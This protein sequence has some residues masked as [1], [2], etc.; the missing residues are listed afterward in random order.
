MKVVVFGQALIHEPV[1][2]SDDL[3]A[4]TQGA[5]AVICNFEGCLPPPEVWPMKSKTVHAAHPASL[6][7]L[8]DL[9]VTHLSVANNH[10]WDF[11]H[12]GIVSTVEATTAAGFVVA[13]AGRTRADAATPAIRN[14]VALLAVDAGPTPDWAIAGQHPG[15]NALRVQMSLG[16]PVNDI[17]RLQEI[18]R[19]SGD[20][21]RRSRRRDIGYDADDGLETFYGVPLSEGNTP[22]E[23]WTVSS[24]DLS[25]LLD[26]IQNARANADL[27]VVSIHY[28]HWRPDWQGPPN[29]LTDVAETL[30]REGADCACAT[31]P[32]VAFPAHTLGAKA[33]ALGLG[34]LVF[35]TARGA[36]YDQL[37]LPVWLG[38]ALTFTD[39]VWAT[40][41]VDC[42]RSA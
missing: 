39:G 16:L 8:R 2:W 15:V 12:A 22:R 19:L 9:G 20:A 36:R 28:H 5:D 3:R 33:V 29:W 27:V 17:T 25:T 18:S 21:E 38:N 4:L 26:A 24:N 11:G 41:K 42:S 14:G 32:P 1:I 10:I 37:G 34:N 35:H 23:V 30:L 31:G 13:G 7:M 40:H 6:D